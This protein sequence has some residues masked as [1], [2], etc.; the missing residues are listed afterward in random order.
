MIYLGKDQHMNRRAVI[1][2]FRFTHDLKTEEIEK[3][4]DIFSLGT[5]MFQLLTGVLPFTG[6]SPPDLLNTIMNVSPPD[7][8][9]FNPKIVK[10]LVAVNH[11][12]LVK[13]RQKRYQRASQMSAH[14]REVGKRMDAAV[15][16]KKAAG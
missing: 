3:L 6:D 13:L 7:P 4:S 12:A 8:R 11:H 5:M 10:P 9:K 2:T 1:K 14:L 15:I 16:K